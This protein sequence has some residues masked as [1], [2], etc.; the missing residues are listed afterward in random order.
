MR[1]GYLREI[2]DLFSEK[3]IIKYVK[4][5]KRVGFIICP[6]LILKER[7]VWLLIFRNKLKEY[8]ISMGY[9]KYRSTIGCTP[10]PALAFTCFQL[11][12]QGFSSLCIAM[13]AA[14]FHAWCGAL[15]PSSHSLQTWKPPMSSSKT[16]ISAA[17]RTVLVAREMLSGLRKWAYPLQTQTHGKPQWKWWQMIHMDL[18]RSHCW[19][20]STPVLYRSSSYWCILV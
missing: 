4:I 20:S 14:I 15:C 11:C 16:W 17:Q 12:Q 5:H 13:M 7:M 3:N 8:D 6:L 9:S 19:S 10:P 18:Y 2:S 1:K